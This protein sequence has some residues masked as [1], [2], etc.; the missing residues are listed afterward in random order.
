MAPSQTCRLLALPAELR[1]LIWVFT[2]TH[3]GKI[4]LPRA[5]GPGPAWDAATSAALLCT[6][7]Q[8][9]SEATSLYEK[10][11]KQIWSTGHFIIDGRRYREAEGKSVCDSFNNSRDALQDD[12]TTLRIRDD[13]LKQIKHV[14]IL[15]SG[16]VLTLNEGIWEQINTH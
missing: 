4:D 12:I 3:E 15:V 6:C 2:F 5:R 1:T 7:R 13:D 16:K 14:D 11:Q 8:I 10:A 9:Q